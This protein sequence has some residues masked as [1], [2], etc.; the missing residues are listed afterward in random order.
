M[1]TLAFQTIFDQAESISINTRATVAQTISRSNVVRSVKRGGQVW[2]F[3]VRLPDGMPW[4]EMRPYIAQIEAADRYTQ[5]IV[6]INNSGYNTWLTPYQGNS[7][8]STGFA[9]SWTQGSN[10]ITLTSSPTTAS[11][12]KFKAGDFI[13][14]NTGRCYVVAANV[15]YN[16]NTVTLN[17]PVLDT[18]GSGALKVGPNCT[19]TV[20]CTDIPSWTIF[21]RDQV[22]WSGAFVFYEAML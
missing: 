9:A 15:A 22:S 2:R 4:S 5:G 20:I 11:G 12:Y 21:S 14:L 10:T 6:Q 18:T 7:A 13:Q 3:E 16:S 19:W 1:T 17:R 8:N